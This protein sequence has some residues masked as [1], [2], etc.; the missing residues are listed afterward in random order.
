MELASADQTNSLNN[1]RSRYSVGHHLFLS[2]L[3]IWLRLYTGKLLYSWAPGSENKPT[4][5]PC[6]L[7]KRLVMANYYE[8]AIVGPQR[9]FQRLYRLYVEMI[10]WFVQ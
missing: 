9:C 3:S 8:G 7:Q 10:A 5:N 6:A 1:C 2:R 4:L